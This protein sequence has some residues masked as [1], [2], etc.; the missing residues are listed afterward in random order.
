MTW[1]CSSKKK[2][3]TR[4]AKL[5]THQ[6]VH[7]ENHNRGPDFTSGFTASNLSCSGGTWCTSGC[8]ENSSYTWG[9]LRDISLPAWLSADAT[10]SVFLNFTFGG[11]PLAFLSYTLSMSMI[12]EVIFTSG[13]LPGWSCCDR[14]NFLCSLCG[15]SLKSSWCVSCC[16]W[17][18][19][20]YTSGMF[21]VSPEFTSGSCS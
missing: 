5:P 15:G 7:I 18:G 1:N 8:D 4:R 21:R 13:V 2:F 10:L 6:K 14:V 11:W 20:E 9:L 3:V 17:S 16:L 19:L 12:R